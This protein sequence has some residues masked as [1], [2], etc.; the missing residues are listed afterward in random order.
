MVDD[1]DGQSPASDRYRPGAVLPYPLAHH[2]D[3][4]PAQQR[5]DPAQLAGQTVRLAWDCLA[6]IGEGE[7]S[8]ADLCQQF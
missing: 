1:A 8:I 3:A 2:L 6:V 7:R 5:R 4:A